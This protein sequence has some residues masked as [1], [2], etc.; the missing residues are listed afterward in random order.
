MEITITNQRNERSLTLTV[1]RGHISQ[2]R[3]KEALAELQVSDWLH[4]RLHDERGMRYEWL[5][6]GIGDGVQLFSH[7]KFGNKAALKAY[8]TQFDAEL[9]R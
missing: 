5:E 3:W 8:W 4:V 7:E 9:S 1:P 2:R 6:H